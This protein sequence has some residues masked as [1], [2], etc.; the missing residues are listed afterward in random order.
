M[1]VSL[2]CDSLFSR[3]EFLI[4]KLSLRPKTCRD[5]DLTKPLASV[6]AVLLSIRDGSL[7]GSGP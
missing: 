6:L 7:V 3:S 1:C 5:R 2:G 4:Y